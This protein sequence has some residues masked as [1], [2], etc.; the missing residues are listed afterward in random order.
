MRL[1]VS[2][3]SAV[4]ASAALEGGA[5][6]IDAKDPAS[7]VLTAVS[8]DVFREIHAAVAGARPVT[9]AA[10]NAA[11]EETIESAT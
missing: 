3:A 1:L 2:V 10:G 6:L 8:A 7:G 4:E 11:D 5:D 9:A